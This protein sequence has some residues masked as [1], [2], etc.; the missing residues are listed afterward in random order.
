MQALIGS[1][2][3]SGVCFAYSLPKLVVIF[4][5]LPWCPMPPKLRKLKCYK[6]LET[7]SS[8]LVLD[9]REGELEDSGKEEDDS[10]I[11]LIATQATSSL[12]LHS[13]LEISS[14]NNIIT[15]SAKAADVN[16]NGRRRVATVE[17]CAAAVITNVKR[18][19]K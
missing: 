14:N 4:G 8:L 10:I 6:E 13:V 11:S 1:I 17:P 16:N 19:L 18:F 7:G 12:F 5:A 15:A 9:L 3:L 2:C